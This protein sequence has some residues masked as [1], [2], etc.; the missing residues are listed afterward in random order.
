MLWSHFFKFIV[1]F[2]SNLGLFLTSS[3]GWSIGNDDMGFVFAVKLETGSWYS[4]CYSF[5]ARAEITLNGY[6]SA[7]ISVM[8]FDATEEKFLC[9][10]S[11]VFFHSECFCAFIYD[12]GFC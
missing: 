6:S 9:P 7:S 8:I 3:V 5:E 10:I 12:M 4:V 1:E 2:F 11:V